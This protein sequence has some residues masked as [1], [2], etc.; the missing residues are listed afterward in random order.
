MDFLNRMRIAKRQDEQSHNLAVKRER[1][2]SAEA[3]YHSFFLEVDKNE[4]KLFNDLPERKSES[5]ERIMKLF[6]TNQKEFRKKTEEINAK[7]PIFTTN[8]FKESLT[9]MWKNQYE[10]YNELINYLNVMEEDYTTLFSED[11]KKKTFDMAKNG[12]FIFYE[13]TPDMEELLCDDVNINIRNALDYFAMD[14]F[15]PLIQ[16]LS[17]IFTENDPDDFLRTVKTRELKEAVSCLINNCYGSCA[18]TML[19]LIENEH[20]NASSINR[21]FFNDRITHGKERSIEI[22]KQLGDINITYFSQCWELMDDYYREITSNANKKSNR[23]I[24][25]NEV[26]HGVYWDAI[27]PNRDSCTELILFYL[28]F[29]RI[30]YFLQEIYDMK[31]NVSE[32]FVTI[33]AREAV[34]NA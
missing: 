12:L 34:K 29:K 4:A 23:Y 8:E 22:S 13:Q 6:L 25:R 18:R 31:T 2:Y 27:L 24:N 17:A 21:D 33:M 30:S 14:D 1:F 5:F 16:M 10:Y 20:T 19:A 26:V 28:S 7:Y 11:Y 9:E 32:E 3:K 15:G